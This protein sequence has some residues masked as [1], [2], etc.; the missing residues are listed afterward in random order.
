MKK[1]LAFL[2]AVTTCFCA[3]TACGNTDDS[4]EKDKSN[5]SSSEDSDKSSK[6]NKD[7]KDNNDSENEVYLAAFQ[8]LI[9]AAAAEDVTATVRATLPDTT[10]NAIENTDSM[11][12]ISDAMGSLAGYGFDNI[13]SVEIVT[14]DE[15]DADVV[16]K[17]EKLYSVYSNMFLIMDENDISYNDVMNGNIDED[18]AML[19]MDAAT[20]LTQINNFDSLDVDLSVEFE[21]AKMVTFSY[22][23]MEEK[24]VV[25]KVAGEDWKV[26]TIG[27]DAIGY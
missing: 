13:T 17:L 11:D 20:Q 18:K 15:C 16:E 6:K 9:D 3:F 2:M 27:I 8:K 7:D 4:S 24:A 19:I 22:N 25:Y 14:V 23:N 10:M 5:K 12:A 26:D 1:I 21:E